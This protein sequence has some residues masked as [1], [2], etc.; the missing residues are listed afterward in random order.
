MIRKFS[1]ARKGTEKWRME[2]LMK[3]MKPCLGYA[4]KNGD[5]QTGEMLQ[6]FFCF[7][8]MFNLRGP[9]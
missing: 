9:P 5:H 3:S 2:S 1:E 8:S 4:T 7:V 6:I